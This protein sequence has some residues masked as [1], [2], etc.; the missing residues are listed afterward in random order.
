M[1]DRELLEL[2]AKACGYDTSNH[3]NAE[4]LKLDP[5]VIGLVIDG[6]STNWNPI[7]ID[8]Q[9]LRLAVTLRIDLHTSPICGEAVIV[10]AKHRLRSDL[11]R[12]PNPTTASESFNPCPYAATRR[13]IVRAAAEIGKSRESWP[14]E[15]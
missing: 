4:R 10:T 6:V 2:A 1:N 5:P 12:E 13:A 14:E 3:W 7:D 8:G 9:A 15:R 11:L